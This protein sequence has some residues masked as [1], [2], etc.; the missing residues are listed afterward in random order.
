MQAALL[1]D[2]GIIKISGADARRF[3][4]GLLTADIERMTEATPRY[5][6]LLTPQGKIIADL[7]VAQSADAAGACFLLDCERSLAAM[8]VA[9]LGFYKLRAKVAVEDVADTMAV[10]ALW[11]EAPASAARE[12][13]SPWFADPRLAALGW[14]AIVPPATAADTVRTQGAALGDAA[15]YE[16]HRIALGVPRGGVDFA[17]GDAFPHEADMDQL[18]GVDFAKGCYVGQEVVS[19][20]QH[21]ATVRSRVVPV[22]IE[23]VAPE[24]GTPV[25][26]G[27]KTLGAMGSAAGGRGL[28]LL[29]LDRVADATAAGL[30]LV[31][32]SARLRPVEPTW[33]GSARPGPT[34]AAKAAG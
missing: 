25:L 8:L 13:G 16:A 22:L 1:P 19:R 3:L 5:A 14:R 28:A 21:R 17:Y 4:H 2:R 7:L 20:M 10:L 18:N 31:A 32:G 12:P 34:S 15:A 24:A 29:R 11:D 23:G 26:A 27:E 6:A 9:K 33:A 30:A